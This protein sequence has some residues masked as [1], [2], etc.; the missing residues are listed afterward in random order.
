MPNVKSGT[1]VKNDVLLEAV[2]SSKQ[3]MIEYRINDGSFIMSKIGLRNFSDEDL[4]RNFE[5]LTQAIIAKRPETVKGKY[6]LRSAI[7][8]SMGPSVPIDMD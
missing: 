7:S 5:E 2:K 1:L 8:T 6:L 4:A 3:G